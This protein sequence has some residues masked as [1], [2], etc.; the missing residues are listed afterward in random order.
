M[1][2]SCAM[3]PVASVVVPVKTLTEFMIDALL[4]MGIPREDAGIVT[5]VLLASDLNGHNLGF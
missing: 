5:E 2:R 3:L 4:K 1:T